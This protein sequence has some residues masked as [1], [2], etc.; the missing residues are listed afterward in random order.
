M[1]TQANDLLE[2]AELLIQNNYT[3]FSPKENIKEATYLFFGDDKNVGYVEFRK[4]NGFHFTTVHYPNHSIGTGFES[5]EQV[6]PATIGHIKNSFSICP[7]WANSYAGSVRKYKGIMDY[8][9]R[10]KTLK[11]Y[12]VKL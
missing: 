6:L 10:E 1:R 2:L 3:V 7:Q 12:E 9:K 5:D 4:Y 8:I 11:Y